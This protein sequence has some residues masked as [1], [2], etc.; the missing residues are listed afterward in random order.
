MG[1]VNGW[2]YIEDEKGRR[3]LGR[4]VINFFTDDGVLVATTMTESDGGFTFLGLPPGKY[5]AQVDSA[6]LT[7]LKMVSTP[8]KMDF[9]LEPMYDGDIVYDLRFVIMSFEEE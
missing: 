1:E 9:E 7:G 8:L 6:Q 2:V 3:G 5:Y 4:I